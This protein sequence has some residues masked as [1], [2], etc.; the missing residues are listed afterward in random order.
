MIREAA[1]PDKMTQQIM[2][3]TES[4]LE[5]I[6]HD[7]TAAGVET[8]PSSSSDNNSS[9]VADTFAG[10]KQRFKVRQ[11]NPIITSNCKK[12]NAKM[13]TYKKIANINQYY[14]IR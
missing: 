2:P 4:I 8:M 11:F 3:V 6:T 13:I 5:E 10:K 1:A 12:L 7:E 14:Y 9:T